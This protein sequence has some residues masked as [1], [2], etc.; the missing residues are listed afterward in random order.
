MYVSYVRTTHIGSS[1][2]QRNPHQKLRSVRQDERALAEA[3]C[4]TS[5]VSYFVSRNPNASQPFASLCDNRLSNGHRA[6]N[7]NIEYHKPR[8]TFLSVRHYF[9]R[10][11]FFWTA[12]HVLMLSPT[13]SSIT[14]SRQLTHAFHLLCLRV[15]SGN[16]KHVHNVNATII[17]EL[18]STNRLL[19]WTSNYS[20]IVSQKYFWPLPPGTALHSG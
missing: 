10:P 19:L 20:D 7:S 3:Q 13:T 11:V 5:F 16:L 4:S 2:H 17:I 12:R 14:S 8:R 15:S 9:Q 18:R 6:V 1:S